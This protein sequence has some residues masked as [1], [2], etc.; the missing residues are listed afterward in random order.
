M[1]RLRVEVEGTTT[2]G[3]DAV[4][5]LVADADRY[6]EWGPWDAS[7]YERT[8]EGSRHGVGAIRRMRYRRTTTV[9][10]VLEVEEGRRIAYTVVK[11]IPV[12]NYRGEVVLT[13]VAGGTRIHWSATWDGTLV[14]RIVHLKLCTFIP[15][16][17]ADLV[18][19]ADLEA[20]PS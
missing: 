14:G 19:A 17:V 20:S 11:G 3:Q 7:G 13:P 1:T 6:A 18:A 5:A 8:G 2:A 9:E 15:G 4:W 12:R 10:Q 16:A